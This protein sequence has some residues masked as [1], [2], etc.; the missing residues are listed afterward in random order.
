M[1]RAAPSTTTGQRGESATSFDQSIGERGNPMPLVTLRILPVRV[2]SK[3][4][5]AKRRKNAA[6]GEAVGYKP[7]TKPRRGESFD[8]KVALKGHRF[9]TAGKS[10]LKVA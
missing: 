7:P 5:A 1:N 6:H 2:T 3:R 8:L 9:V 10:V 4:P